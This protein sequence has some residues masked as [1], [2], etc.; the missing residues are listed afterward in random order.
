[1]GP[2]YDL[3]R[4]LN[5]ASPISACLNRTCL[6]P[7]NLFAVSHRRLV[8]LVLANPKVI[9]ENNWKWCREMEE[10]PILE[11]EEPAQIPVDMVQGLK[12]PSTGVT[13]TLPNTEDCSPTCPCGLLLKTVVVMQSRHKPLQLGPSE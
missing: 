10:Q 1:M 9:T 13:R 5:D 7:F 3:E 6:N 2:E 8:C 12:E 11:I 4:N